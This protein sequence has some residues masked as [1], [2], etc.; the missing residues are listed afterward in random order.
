MSESSIY[1]VRH[2]RYGS[3]ELSN[4]GRTID[5]PHARDELIEKGLGNGALLLSSSRKRAVQTAEIIGEGL[6]VPP[7]V[8]EC[9]AKGADFVRGIKSLDEF[10]AKSLIEVDATK[11]EGQSLVVVTHAP[12]L[13]VAKG[14][15]W[16]GAE[17]DIGYGEVVEYVPGSWHNRKFSAAEEELLNEILEN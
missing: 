9:V 12:L 3:S 4:E 10:L 7:L 13:A 17:N 1:L 14:W 6:G 5:A 2:G 8:S 11:E 16:R 15:F